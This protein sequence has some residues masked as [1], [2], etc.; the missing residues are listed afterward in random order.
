MDSHL[1]WIDESERKKT[2]RAKAKNES[3]PEEELIIPLPSY[4]KRSGSGV[5]PFRGSAV[6]SAKPH[7][8][9]L[10]KQPSYAY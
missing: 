1:Y 2:L 3:L 4:A 7:S 10:H 9:T 5:K 6:P 8:R